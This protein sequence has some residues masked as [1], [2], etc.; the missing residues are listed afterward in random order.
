LKSVR[1]RR[2]VLT[3]KG[4]S[5]TS[6]SCQR[7]PVMM[8]RRV[9]HG[10][11]RL[12]IRADG[13]RASLSPMVGPT[14]ECGLEQGLSLARARGAMVSRIRSEIRVVRL[15][16]RLARIHAP[17]D[18]GEEDQIRSP[19]GPQKRDLRG[20]TSRINRLGILGKLTYCRPTTPRSIVS[21][22]SGLSGLV[23]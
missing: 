7:Y 20:K 5:A 14:S 17:L 15:A 22:S 11:R 16:K 2:D 9:L 23:E 13:F 21:N 19:Q 18:C 3:T 6:G 4:G 1:R 10:C 12:L 8:L